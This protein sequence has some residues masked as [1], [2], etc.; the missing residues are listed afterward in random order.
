MHPAISSRLS[1]FTLGS[2][3]LFMGCGGKT[4]PTPALVPPPPAYFGQALPGEKPVIFTT[5]KLQALSPWIEA[6]AFSPDGTVFSTV[7]GSADYS[8]AVLHLSTYVDGAWTAITPAPFLADF[9]SSTEPVFSADGTTL[10]FTGKKAG[11]VMHFWT[12]SYANKTWG[13]PVAMP[14]P[15]NNETNS[16]RGSYTTDGTFY[17]GSERCTNPVDGTI[18]IYKAFKNSTQQWEVELLGPTINTGI[19]ECDP[20]IASDGRFIVFSSARDQLTCDLFVSFRTAQGGWGEAINLGPDFNQTR[21]SAGN[22][23]QEYGPHLSVDGKYLFYT[24][25]TTNGTLKG[26]QILW[27]SVSAI[28]KFKP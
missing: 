4:D 5:E 23:V 18:E 13:T 19:Y 15:F 10:M 7:V 26:D 21:N 17:F 2:S 12:V 8:G 20:C 3:M 28:D 11:G 22:G 14:S 24:R 27:V 1:L 6:T 9:V 25:H 16:W